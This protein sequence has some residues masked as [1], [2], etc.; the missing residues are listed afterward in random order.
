MLIVEAQIMFDKQ[1]LSHDLSTNNILRPAFNFGRDLLFSGNILV[2]Q[3]IKILER[4]KWY[5]VIIELPTIQEEVY[6]HI[7]DL[8]NIGNTFYMHRASKVLGEG[9]IINFL[10]DTDD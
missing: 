9:I 2:D 4:N 1:N 8:I 6:Y 10:F 3:N 7:Q 5:E